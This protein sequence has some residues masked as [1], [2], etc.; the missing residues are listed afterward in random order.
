MDCTIG[1]RVWVSTSGP[2]RASLRIGNPVRESLQADSII[3]LLSLGLP[4]H[5]RWFNTNLADGYTAGRNNDGLLN[6]SRRKEIVGIVWHVC[7][8]LLSLLLRVAE[9]LYRAA[10]LRPPRQ[11][12]PLFRAATID[13]QCRV[14]SVAL[15]PR[16]RV[17]SPAK[18]PTM[19]YWIIARGT[20]WRMAIQDRRRRPEG[21]SVG[22]RA[23]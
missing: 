18:Q 16:P 12:A 14:S 1:P 11:F 4:K 19:R 5:A 8:V 20:D 15:S 13:G 7:F 6:V 17:L 9:T 10:E 3:L 22:H 23:S 2:I 21:P